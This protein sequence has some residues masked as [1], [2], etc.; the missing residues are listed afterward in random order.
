M[1]VCVCVLDVLRNGGP[2]V[3]HHTQ[4]LARDSQG[5]LSPKICRSPMNHG[6]AGLYAQFTNS[7]D[8]HYVTLHFTKATTKAAEGRYGPLRAAKGR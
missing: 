8:L 2:T 7:K 5:T 1:C 4:P 3:G 6:V